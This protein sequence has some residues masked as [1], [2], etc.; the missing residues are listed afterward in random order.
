MTLEL[1]CAFVSCGLVTSPNNR[2]LCSWCPDLWCCRYIATE[3]PANVLSRFEGLRGAGGTFFML[4]Q[5][6]PDK[7][8]LWGGET[9]QVCMWQARVSGPSV[10]SRWGACPVCTRPHEMPQPPTANHCPVVLCHAH[11][12]TMQ[13]RACP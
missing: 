5:L 7:D 3:A 6:Q 1:D 8:A 11:V 10:G 12:S 13:Q 2:R 4:D 9:P